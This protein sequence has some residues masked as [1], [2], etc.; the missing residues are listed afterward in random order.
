MV[1]SKMDRLLFAKSLKHGIYLP[2]T[3]TTHY[4]EVLNYSV[5][6]YPTTTA[7]AWSRHAD[8]QQDPASP[9][10]LSNWHRF[11][12]N[13]DDFHNYLTRKG[14]FAPPTLDQNV[15]FTNGLRLMLQQKVE[16]RQTFD[17]H[18][19]PFPKDDYISL[20]TEMRLPLRSVEAT[21]V[22][23]PFFWWS[24]DKN[25]E[26]PLL[27]FI[28]RKSDVKLNEESRGWEM[29]LSYSFKT[30][31]TSGFVKGTESARLETDILPDLKECSTPITHPLLLPFLILNSTLSSDNDI[32]QRKSR[33]KIRRLEN[34]LSARYRDPK[35]SIPSYTA[36]DDDPELGITDQTPPQP[37]KSKADDH[38]ELDKINQELTDC[39][40]QVLWKRPQAWQNVVGRLQEAAEAFWGNLSEDDRNLPGFAE[41]HDSIVSRLRFIGIKLEGLENYTHVSLERLNL[42]REVMH[43][44]LDQRES[45][46]N[47][48]MAVQQQLL[49]DSSRRDGMS[50]KTLSI[51][52][53]LFLPGTFLSSM[54]SMPF[55]EFSSDM[56]DGPVSKRLWIYFVLMVPVTVLVLGFWLVFDKRSKNVTES[57]V[58]EAKTRMQA[59]MHALESRI[60]ERIRDRIGARIK[61]TDTNLE[62]RMAAA[63]GHGNS[64]QANTRPRYLRWLGR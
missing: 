36:E 38:L 10:Q 17:P 4:L 9:H 54:F 44:I 13:I 64:T 1:Q 35:H 56:G 47:L 23:G 8:F 26:N 62:Q 19:I 5:I 53:A 6:S 28:F 46:L 22:V 45:R 2:Q 59:R 58:D 37:K 11:S 52:G 29:M 32:Q 15:S 51:L 57:D 34:A 12:T 43:S 55:F 30:R 33:E 31:I 49:A 7:R 60:T 24:I 14:V 3:E 39:H 41:L 16:D 50:M 18:I 27:Q 63:A 42:Q 20:V 61:T 40:C 48:E 25:P 21:S